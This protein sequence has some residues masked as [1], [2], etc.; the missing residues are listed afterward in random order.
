VQT[1]TAD[2]VKKKA[3]DPNLSRTTW[4]RNYGDLG[5][6]PELNELQSDVNTAYGHYWTL[7][8]PYP[9]L[10]RVLKVMNDNNNNPANRISLPETD[11]DLSDPDSWFSFLKTNMDVQDFFTRDAPQNIAIAQNSSISTDYESRWSA[12]GSVSYGFFSV[13]GSASGGSI[14]RHLREGTQSLTFQFQRLV[15]MPILRGQWY[16][17]GLMRLPYITYV[18]KSEYWSV[19]GQL[20]LVPSIALV[21]RG[22]KVSVATSSLAYDEFQ[23]WH[24]S[25]GSA[26]FSFGPWSVGGGANSST[27]SSS[28]T[29]TSTGT[30]ISFTDNSNTPYVLAVLSLKMEDWLGNASLYRQLAEAQVKELM[31]TALA[32]EASRPALVQ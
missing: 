24:N 12:G 19:T 3:A 15:P 5:Y 27:S 32:H 4:D 18:D 6:T 25:S 21:G 8:N 23:S 22:L 9:E 13:G 1:A 2:W 17:E 14:E 26:G 29:N 31:Q 7:A 28:V 20:P 10:A 30:T 11:D 16:D